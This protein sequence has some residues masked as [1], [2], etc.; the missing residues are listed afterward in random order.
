MSNVKLYDH[1]LLI[2]IHG[3]EKKRRPS[4][5]RDVDI[6]LGTNNLEA[7]FSEPIPKREWGNNIRGKIIQKFTELNIPIA[8]GHPTR[9]EY[10]LKGGLI[11]KK[12]GASQIHRSQALQIE[13]SDSIRLYDK[14][15]RKV[16]IT[17]LAEVFSEYLESPNY[18]SL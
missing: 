8:P 13:F 7:F 3:F 2:D 12:Y 18:L 14:E 10:V 17:T 11:T 6:I 16:V 5:F 4:G 1:S 15:L 9:K